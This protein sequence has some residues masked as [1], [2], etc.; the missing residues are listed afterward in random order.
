M[1]IKKKRIGDFMLIENPKGLEVRD[2]FSKHVIVDKLNL[3]IDQIKGG[4]KKN[5]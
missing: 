3:T 1:L 5:G 4:K 2:K